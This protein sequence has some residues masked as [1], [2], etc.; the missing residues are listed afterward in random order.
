M[1]INAAVANKVAV[2]GLANSLS[3]TV[4]AGAILYVSLCFDASGFVTVDPTILADGV[5]MSHI[6]EEKGERTQYLYR[7]DAPNTGPQTIT[8][9]WSPN[10]FTSV[11]TAFEAI[12]EV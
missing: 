3:Y 6:A 4:S 10:N 12:T 9:T 1:T 7:L 8:A 11:M 5:A 2:A